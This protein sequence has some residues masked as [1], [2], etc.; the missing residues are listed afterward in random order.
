MNNNGDVQQLLK[1]LDAVLARFYDRAYAARDTGCLRT[2]SFWY[3]SAEDVD[4]VLK[5]F[6]GHE[7]PDAP[8]PLPF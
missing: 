7:H 1:G 3:R 6:R 2:A 8:S 5:E 4:A